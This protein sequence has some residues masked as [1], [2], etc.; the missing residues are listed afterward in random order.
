MMEDMGRLF[1]P[2]PEEGNWQHNAVVGGDEDDE[3]L[4][5]GFAEAGDLIVQSWTTEGPNDLPFVPFVYLY[6]HAFELVLKA[7]IRETAARLRVEHEADAEIDAS[8]LNK[9][10]TRKPLGHNLGGLLDL[11]VHL[12]ARLS[13]EDELPDEV[14]ETIRQLDSIDPSGEAFRYAEV[15][16]PG[17]SGGGGH[18]P[19]Y[20]LARP[21]QQHI[22]VVALGTRLRESFGVLSAGVMSVLGEY[23]EY[24]SAMHDF[25]GI[26]DEEH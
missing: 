2:V 15:R 1:E 12:L 9:R 3:L 17:S 13:L 25:H 18:S 26:P 22:D 5:M 4:A 19:S 10:M 16:A 14:Q 6:R 11:L 23:A 21:D 20:V 8:D 7:A 24:Q